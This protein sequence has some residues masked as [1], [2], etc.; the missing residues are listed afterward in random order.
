MEYN[1]IYYSGAPH[2]SCLGPTQLKR[3]RPEN[4][5]LSRL[6]TFIICNGGISNPLNLIRLVNVEETRVG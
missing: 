5:Q 2:G 1:G 4:L 3:R 6:M